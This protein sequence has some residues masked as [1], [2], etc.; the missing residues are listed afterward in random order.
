[1]A[2]TVGCCWG[3]SFVGLRGQVGS[4]AGQRWI[5]LF[6]EAVRWARKAQWCVCGS[7]RLGSGGMIIR[8]TQSNWMKQIQS[9]FILQ[10]Q[11]LLGQLYQLKQAISPC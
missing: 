11:I 4:K 2:G 6:D 9:P 7:F 10:N 1:M 5:G 3:G 8:R